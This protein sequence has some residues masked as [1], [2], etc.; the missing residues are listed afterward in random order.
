MDSLTEYTLSDQFP[1]KS[2]WKETVK[3]HIYEY[4]NNLWQEKISTRSQL[5]IYA[6]I[7]PVNEI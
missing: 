6:E 1:S 7:H 2:A 5:K 3:K 4:Y